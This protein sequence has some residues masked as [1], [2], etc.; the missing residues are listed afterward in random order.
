MLD[1]PLLIALTVVTVVYI[2]VMVILLFKLIAIRRRLSSVLKQKDELK[3]SSTS[4]DADKTNSGKPN[5]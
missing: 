4:L 2:I 3:T 5:G 1:S